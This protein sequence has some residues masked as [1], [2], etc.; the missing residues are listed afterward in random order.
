MKKIIKCIALIIIT[1]LILISLYIFV[2]CIRIN[3]KPDSKPLIVIDKIFCSKD[4]W[5]CYKDGKYTEEYLSL[6]FTLKTDYYLDSKSSEDNLIY[7]WEK[8]SMYLFN[9]ILLFEK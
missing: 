8:T 9:K 3:N 7:H 4:S 1:T 6:G 2:E 5:V